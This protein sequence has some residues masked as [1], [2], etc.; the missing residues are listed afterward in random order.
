MS[1]VPMR[2]ISGVRP[3]GSPLEVLALVAG[4]SGKVTC[5]RATFQPL[6]LRS[7]RI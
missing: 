4:F 6:T 5:W 1:Q 2:F 7:T 3:G